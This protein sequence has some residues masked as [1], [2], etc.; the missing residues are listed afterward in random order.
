MTFPKNFLWG[1]AIA[2]NQ[3][4]GAYNE[5]GKGLSVADILSV[6]A[7]RFKNV[8]LEINEEKYYPSHEAIDFY[9]TYK[10]DIKELSDLGMKCFRTS[11]A[12]SRIFPNGDDKEPNEKGLEFYDNL[13]DELLKYGME[14]VITIS[15]FETP[16]NLI[17]KYGGWKNRKL[18]DFYSNYCNVIFNRYK[19]KVKYWMTFNE[20]NHAH[21][22][23][24]IAAAIVV[25]E[26]ENKLQDIY[27][28]SHNMLVASAKA[29]I[30]GH[31]INKE[32]K[33]G[34][35]L[36]L[37]P[38]YPASCKP[39]DV[40]ESYELR[41]R[42]LFYS[43]I[44]MLGEY[45]LYFNR[46]AKENNINI[47]ME[48]EDKEILKKGVCDYLGFSYYRSSLHEAGMKI[49]GN[50]GGLL[51]K[52]NPYLSETKWGWPIDPLGLRYVCNELTDRYHKP[53]FIVENGLGA[54]DEITEDGKIHDDERMDYLKKHVIMMNEAIED[55]ADIIGYTW[56][57]PID[58]VSAGTGEMKKRY[59]FV[60]VDKDNN[61]N[62]T[63]KR[64]KKDSYNYYKQI[65]ATNGENLER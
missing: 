5:D 9:H 56:W 52:K 12:W 41:R 62:G 30:M 53:L 45:P 32:F 3:A 65:I 35:M 29:V 50:T 44:Q 2:A 25:K 4:E 60:Y 33:I 36:S 16:L 63:L 17:T 28:A 24:L 18:I 43:D 48:D 37:S 20:I 6:G 15:H 39:E 34:C 46:I 8:E 59:G 54:I 55:G 26:D 49:L 38:I 58:I 51:G 42:S 31:E 57:G 22:L 23:P 14:P 10:E 13:F 27:Q 40:F 64:I 47:E 7:D 21:T 61:G 1:G 11:I 19:D